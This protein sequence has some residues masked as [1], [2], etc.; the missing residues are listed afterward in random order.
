MKTLTIKQIGKLLVKNVIW[1]AIVTVAV[2]LVA[3]IYTKAFVRPYYISTSQ[4]YIDITT[5][6]DAP[7]TSA[8]LAAAQSHAANFK[9]FAETRYAQERVAKTLGIED[10][11]GYSLEVAVITGTTQME[12]SIV[13]PNANVAYAICHVMTDVIIEMARDYANVRVTVVDDAVQ[14]DKPA[15]PKLLKTVVVAGIAALLITAIVIIVMEMLN[16]KI[17]NAEDAE[18]ILGLTVLAKI[19]NKKDANGRLKK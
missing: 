11:K 8:Q 1:L 15:G 12:I 7:S 5:G 10:L 9:S 17:K 4:V 16:T 19:P 18:E 14:A 13:G 3:G 2:M 6:E